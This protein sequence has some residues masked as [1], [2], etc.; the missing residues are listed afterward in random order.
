[1]SSDNG[2]ANH[3]LHWKK[4]TWVDIYVL[5]VAF[6]KDGPGSTTWLHSIFYIPL[7][8]ALNAKRATVES[9]LINSAYIAYMTCKTTTS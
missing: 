6:G 4:R 7:T 8:S 1:V 2:E 9:R 3:L 5:E